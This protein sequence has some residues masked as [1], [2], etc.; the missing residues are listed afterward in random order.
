MLQSG[1]P[2]SAHQ[3][4]QR[5]GCRVAEFIE[6]KHRSEGTNEMLLRGPNV[7]LPAT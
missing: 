4:R 6:M 5:W 3:A 7:I 1:V 2:G